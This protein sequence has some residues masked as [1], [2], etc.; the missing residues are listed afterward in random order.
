ME[1]QFSP[2][3]KLSTSHPEKKSFHDG[4]FCQLL[5]LFFSFSC[6]HSEREKAIHFFSSGFAL[7]EREFGRA[8]ISPLFGPEAQSRG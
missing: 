4:V 7:I 3:S 5:K 6:A 1:S 2:I 8:F